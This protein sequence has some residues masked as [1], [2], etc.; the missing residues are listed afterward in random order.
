MR[1]YEIGDPQLFISLAKTQIGPHTHSIM[2]A[3][4]LANSCYMYLQLM[5]CIQITLTAKTEHF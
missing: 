3:I 4:R 1:L 5:L 2:S